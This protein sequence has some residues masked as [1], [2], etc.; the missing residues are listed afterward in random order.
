MG[1]YCTTGS[2]DTDYA[3]FTDTSNAGKTGKNKY[4][5]LIFRVLTR[6]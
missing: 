2:K 1:F 3:K 6:I 5:T 4:N